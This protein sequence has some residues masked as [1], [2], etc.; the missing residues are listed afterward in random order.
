MGYE[1][2]EKNNNNKKTK[3]ECKGDKASKKKKSRVGENTHNNLLNCKVN[4]T[5]TSASTTLCFTVYICCL[6]LFPAIVLVICSARRQISKINPFCY[7]LPDKTE[8]DIWD[9]Y[10]NQSYSGIGH[11]WRTVWQVS[12]L[13]TPLLIPSPRMLQ[14]RLLLCT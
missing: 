4:A 6:L 14:S 7:L 10:R 8:G 13:Y 5:P 1:K 9:P 3:R 11:R 12:Y 2:Y